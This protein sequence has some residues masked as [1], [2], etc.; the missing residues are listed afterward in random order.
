M[1]KIG[2]TD[3]HLECHVSYQGV[4]SWPSARL[5]R[6]RNR[7]DDG[8]IAPDLQQAMSS[9]GLSHS[10]PIGTNLPFQAF[11]SRAHAFAACTSYRFLPPRLAPA[12]SAPLV[13]IPW[14]QPVSTAWRRVGRRPATVSARASTMAVRGRVMQRSGPPELGGALLLHENQTA[15]R[16]EAK[17]I[18]ATVESQRS[19]VR[20]L[21]CRAQSLAVVKHTRPVLAFC[22]HRFPPS[23]LF[24]ARCS[25]AVRLPRQPLV[26]AR[27]CVRRGE[28]SA[29][30]APSPYR[31]DN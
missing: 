12:K 23:I 4:S 29:R 11:F 6:G 20:G 10:L 30:R 7:V 31:P 17:R 9:C 28:L 21:Q 8:R 26:T 5:R 27:Q 14:A 18:V 1:L 19:E 2:R 22:F 13:R 3:C 25:G 15:P 24:V 16:G